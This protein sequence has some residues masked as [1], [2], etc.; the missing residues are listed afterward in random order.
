MAILTQITQHPERAMPEA[1]A[2]ILN[3]GQV[4]HVGFIQ[5]G[6]AYVLP[7]SYHYHPAEPDVIYFH[8]ALKS[9]ALSE[10][11]SGQTVCI[12]V[13]LLDGLVYS[14]TAMFHSM[15]YR[16]VVCFGSGHEVSQAPEKAAVFEAMVLKYFPGRQ[17]GEAYQAP[18]IE[19]LAATRLIRIQLDAKSAKARQGGPKGPGD[20]QAEKPGTA[21]VIPFGSPLAPQQWHR[22]EFCISTDR[23]RLDFPAIYA[24]L[25]AT[26]WAR[27][28]TPETLQRSIEH[29]LC[30]GIYHPDTQVGFARV[31]TDYA[32]FA[33]V[34]DLVIWE[35]W[36]GQGLGT[37]LMQCMVQHPDLQ[38]LWRWFLRTRDAHQLYQKVGFQLV[39]DPERTMEWLP[40]GDSQ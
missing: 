7:F 14:K 19:H 22:S 39:P 33:Y 20:Q 5:D 12:E 35:A 36:Q 37:W 34:C 8:G 18:P 25:K 21:G 30:F 2:D 40:K 29:S 24:A 13:T 11:A 16:S 17:Q 15:N 4:A 28:V 32:T 38:G 23:N 1:I 9:R 31:V 27:K 10:L 26:Y 6:Q 3:Q